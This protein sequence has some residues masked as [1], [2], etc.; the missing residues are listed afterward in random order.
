MNGLKDAKNSLMGSSIYQYLCS[1]FNNQALISQILLPSFRIEGVWETNESFPIKIHQNLNLYIPLFPLFFNI[2]SFPSA[3]SMSVSI[4]TSLTYVW[5]LHIK[6]K[7]ITNV[8]ASLGFRGNSYLLPNLWVNDATGSRTK[9]YLNY[10]Y[11]KYQSYD[12]I[13]LCWNIKL[14]HRF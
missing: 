4:I 10:R 9:I 12:N 13:W 14:L 11:W 6:T 3:L 1:Y 7:I 8:V 5:P 2:P